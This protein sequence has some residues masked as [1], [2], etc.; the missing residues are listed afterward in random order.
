MIS[1]AV[2]SAGISTG[3]GVVLV[4]G[5]FEVMTLG[6]APPST[7]VREGREVNNNTDE[8]IKQVRT[9]VNTIGWMR[10]MGTPGSGDT[11]QVLT[12]SLDHR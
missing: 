5:P 2:S 7:K 12:R 1:P 3:V 8:W 9:M 10:G 11:R 6:S 4:H